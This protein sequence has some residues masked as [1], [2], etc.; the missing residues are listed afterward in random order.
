MVPMTESLPQDFIDYKQKHPEFFPQDQPIDKQYIFYQGLIA[1]EKAR[2]ASRADELR[3]RESPAS[4]SSLPKPKPSVDLEPPK[5]FKVDSVYGDWHFTDFGNAER[6]I[7]K[8]SGDMI[9]FH[10]NNS[11]YIWDG[12]GF[13]SKDGLG[14]AKELAKATLLSIYNETKYLASMESREKAAKWA[15]QCEKNEHVNACLNLAS[16]D[17]RIAVRLEKFDTDKYLFNMLNGTY[18]LKN[19]LFLQHDKLNY[20]TRQVGYN[21]DPDAQ[22][23]KFMKF[24]NRIFKSRKDKDDIIDYIQRALGYSL[25]GEVSQQAIFLLYGSG[26]NGKSTLIETQRMVT[27][28]YGTTVD[29]TSLITKKNDSVRND[30][31]RLPGVRFVSAS[32]NSKGTILDEEL[33]KKLSG[34]D[35]VTARFLFQEEFQFYP[36]LKLW[37]AFNHPP[38]L[39]DFTHSLMRRLKLIPFEEVISGKEIIDQ[40][41]L[42]GWHRE[43]LPGIFNWEL[44][45]L[46]KFQK[47]GLKDIDAVKN[48]VKEF[49]EEQDILHEFI[50]DCCYI[51][52]DE[53]S[54]KRDIVTSSSILYRKYRTWAQ[55][56]NEK[57]MGPRKFSIEMKERGFKKSHK[58]KGSV[59]HNIEIK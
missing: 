26:A 15:I 4:P 55:E 9:Y 1:R 28:D 3:S 50:Q 43:E 35:Q 11:W 54:L 47:E 58:E 41:V 30:I 31:A 25:T 21:Y 51:A 22:C 24:M 32:E 46:K 16:S 59:F 13:W 39:N 40:S 45:G 27:G 48:A 34:G 12:N 42:L 18:D 8:T 53:D 2:I 57:E 33:V 10:Q 23:P 6:L 14:E 20:I 7:A 44:A 17:P 49:K 56:N 36:H 38:G 37:W 5:K 29:S 52:T 19:H